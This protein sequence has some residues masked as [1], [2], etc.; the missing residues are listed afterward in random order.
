MTAACHDVCMFSGECKF[1]ETGNFLIEKECNVTKML[2]SL[3]PKY[4]EMDNSKCHGF[5]VK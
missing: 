5:R 3:S 4:V 2:M 1:I